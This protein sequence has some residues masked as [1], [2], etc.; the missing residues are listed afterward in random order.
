MSALLIALLAAVLLAALWAE[1][2]LVRIARI[3]DEMSASFRQVEDEIR[4]AARRL[5]G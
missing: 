2:L 5:G 4:K 1:W 3:L